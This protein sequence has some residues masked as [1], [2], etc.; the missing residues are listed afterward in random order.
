MTAVT[1][2]QLRRILRA[3]ARGKPTPA[4]LWHAP[5]ASTHSVLVVGDS[6]GAG[7]GCKAPAD[8]VAGRLVKD[9]AHVEMHNASVSGATVAAVVRHVRDLPHTRRFDFVLVFAGG[10][11][12]IRRTPL[13]ALRRSARELLDELH[14]KGE[15]IL[16]VGM[17]NVG[18]APAFLPPFSWWL[19]NR[20]RRVNRLLAE[21][22]ALRGAHF[23]DFFHERSVDPFSATP[24]CYYADDGVH[25][26]AQAHAYCYERMKPFFVGSLGLPQEP[27]I[28]AVPR[29]RGCSPAPTSS[30]GCGPSRLM[31]MVSWF[32]NAGRC[33]KHRHA[34]V[35]RAI[36]STRVPAD[37]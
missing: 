19:T 4:A 33:L 24:D 3:R 35:D 28:V 10:N 20:T 18:L 31:P 6:T 17:A 8:T 13:C 23:V 27:R 9:Y 7:V 36:P 1:G 16:W 25:P 14:V 30:A 15:R 29:S 22:V 37:A 11:D 34:V 2:E 32:V 21:E 5:P 26:S 12:V